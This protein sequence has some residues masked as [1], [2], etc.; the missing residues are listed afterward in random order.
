VPASAASQATTARHSDLV[1]PRIEERQAAAQHEVVVEV[2]GA[3][4]LLMSRHEGAQGVRGD[5][6]QQGTAQ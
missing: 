2:I 5:A 1:A 4:D 6:R 3:D